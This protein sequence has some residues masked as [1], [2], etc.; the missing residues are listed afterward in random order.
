M[1]PITAGLAALSG[2]L[3]GAG[4]YFGAKE[5]AKATKSASKMSA[6]EQ[7]RKTFADLL[8]EALARAYDSS[9]TG[10]QTQAEFAGARAKSLQDLAA[11][12]R[13]SLVR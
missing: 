1:E 13:Q 7:K 12:I 6:K 11:G 8:N 9:K 2:A 5:Q 3:Q 10:R 4:S